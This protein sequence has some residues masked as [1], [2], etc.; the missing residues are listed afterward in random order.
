MRPRASSSSSLLPL[1]IFVCVVTLIRLAYL[2]WW[3][4]YDLVEDEAQYWWWAKFL[5]WSY[6]SKGPG[7]AWAIAAATRIYG[8]AEWAVRLPAAISAAIGIFSVG[9]LTRDIARTTGHINP[10]RLA[11]FGAATFALVPFFQMSAVL[12][13]IDGP[14]IACWAV[15]AWM[16]WRAFFA[17]AHARLLAWAALGAAIGIGFLFK[18]TMLLMLPGIALALFWM[19]PRIA[20]DRT[21]KA[22]MAIAVLLIL[23]ALAPVAIWNAQ[24]DWVTVRH[25]LGHLGVAGGDMPVAG[26]AAQAPREA[27]KWFEWLPIGP[28]GLALMQIGLVGP[29]LIVGAAVGGRAILSRAAAT[30]IA[31]RS[32]LLLAAL[33]VPVIAL[34][35]VVA[36]IAEPEGNWPIVASVTLVPIAAL[37][38]CGVWL[39]PVRDAA[40]G[41]E[42]QPS[43]VEQPPRHRWLRR[44]FGAGILYGALAIFPMHRTDLAA[45]AVNRV[46]AIPTVTQALSSLRKDKLPPAPIVPGRLIGARE[47]GAAVG[48]LMEELRAQTGREP[49]I[50]A[51]HYGRASQMMYYAPWPERTD[52][53]GL[54]V[55]DRQALSASTLTGGRQSHFDFV[56]ELSIDRP[57][58]LGRPAIILSND[59]PEVRQVWERLFDR[60]VEYRSPAG[61]RRLPGEHKR[62]RVAYFGFGYRGPAA[63]PPSNVEVK[64]STDASAPTA[65]P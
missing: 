60:V 37:W 43:L 57:E 18:Y 21:A 24:H 50:L 47:Q 23:L 28:I 7:I 61:S 54:A 64:P 25:L 49:F 44:L 51:Q 8:D 34:Y 30:T 38:R 13:T 22:G 10:A 58:L 45:L 42:A 11:V 26:A 27:R 63:A 40:R 36:Y 29:L 39:W 32:V 12:V 5:S 14:L 31:Q 56:P 15:G 41:P 62:D 6:Y 55:H 17:T 4:P 65:R 52:A 1:F 3:C 53:D 33:A 19:R 46:M 59:R 35:A 2:R 48:K 20:F 9:G 16:C